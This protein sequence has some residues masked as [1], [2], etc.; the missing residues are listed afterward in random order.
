M[1][2][3]L[4][5][6]LARLEE[7]YNNLLNQYHDLKDRNRYIQEDLIKKA[8]EIKEASNQDKNLEKEIRRLREDLHRDVEE[9]EASF[10]LLNKEF[11]KLNKYI[12]AELEFF[13]AYKKDKT[14]IFA[15]IILYALGGMGAIVGFL[16]STGILKI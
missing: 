2:E 8:E 10:I 14:L 6:S 5:V 3:T 15:K 4:E 13:N 16:L 1:A 9:L 7:K 12:E 11:E